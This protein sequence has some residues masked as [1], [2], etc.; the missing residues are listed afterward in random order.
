MTLV[1]VGCASLPILALLL[2][3]H[4]GEAQ[5]QSR[6]H[7]IAASSRAELRSWDAVVDSMDRRGDLRLRQRRNDPLRESRTHDR[8]DQYY[9]G[10][11]VFGG[12]VA[13]QSEQELTVSIF[14]TVYD[15]IGLDPAPSISASEARERIAELAGAD[16]PDAYNPEIVVLPRDEGG[17]DLAYRGRAFGEHG[18]FMYFVD[19]HTGALLLAFDDLKAQSAIGSGLGVLGYAKKLSVHPIGGAYRAED[20]LRPPTLATFDLKGNLART[21]AII[22][23]AAVLTASDLAVDSDNAWTDPAVVDAHAYRGWV[24]DFL[25]KRFGRRG[26][27]DANVPVASIVHPVDRQAVLQQTS[28][29]IGTFYLNAFYA[30]DGLMVFGEGL[31]SNLVDGLR[32]RRLPVTPSSWRS[33][34][35]R[36]AHRGCP[37]PA[38]AAAGGNRLKKCSIAHSLS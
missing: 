4:D 15:G 33:R 23:G 24:Y 37:L 21:L 28:A 25:F 20:E 18:L 36:T 13:R 1:R 8:F 38:S 16:L 10:V 22:S 5:T 31:P 34:A 27:D 11:R 30:G 9:R 26:L 32:T 3:T 12:D 7:H 6:P 35:A 14:G 19:A 29:T 2:A 17:Y